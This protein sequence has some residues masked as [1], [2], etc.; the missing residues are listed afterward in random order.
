LVNTFKINDLWKERNDRVILDVRTPA[1][2]EKGHIP[3]ALN[4]PLFSN[5]ERAIVGTI[6][7]QESP[8]KALLQGLDFVGTKMTDFIEKAKQVAPR[9]QV[10]IQCWRGG[11]RSS[12][13]AWL[14]DLAGFDVKVLEGG[15]N[16]YKRFIQD[17]N[18]IESCNFI[19]LGGKT[20]SGKTHILKAL[21]LAGEQVIDL[22]SLANHKGSAFG[23]IG[24]AVQPTTEQFENDLFEQL[25]KLDFNKRIWLENESRNI[26]SVYLPDTI[27][28]KMKNTP[29][30]NIEVSL[31]ERVQ[32][33]VEEYAQF[34]KED[35]L[36]AFYKI[37]KRL[38][39]QNLK[40]AENALNENNYY[41]A[42]EIAL[43]YYD[44]S[45][46]FLLENNKA[47]E[48]HML[49]IDKFDPEKNAKSLVEFCISNAPNYSKL[50]T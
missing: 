30:I 48:I 41:K 13:M 39:G 37:K 4:L 38:G 18:Q 32:I 50:N 2:Y 40:E 42:A 19:V 1:E 45:Y 16:A 5:E 23:W 28:Q 24:E 34:S 35:L 17:K 10:A 31:K 44:K 3:G 36:A 12:S 7:K 6:Y 33:L 9:K 22:E 27:W 49:R 25:F 11:K 21:K 47:P 8:E 20:G 43:I 46:Q 29:L 15:Y 14:L 26:G